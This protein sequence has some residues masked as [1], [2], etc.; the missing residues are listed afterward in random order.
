M[1]SNREKIVAESASV[2]PRLLS[3]NIHKN[4]NEIETVSL[5]NASSKSSLTKPNISEFILQAQYATLFFNFGL[6][7]YNYF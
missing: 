7:V 5:I 2:I 4:K 1:K 3:M 6:V